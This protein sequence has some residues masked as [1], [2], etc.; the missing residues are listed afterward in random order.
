MTSK[1]GLVVGGD[2][3]RIH[4]ILT[5]FFTS[6]AWSSERSLLLIIIIIII[7]IINELVARALSAAAIPNTKEPQGLCR[8]DRKRP[9]GLTLVP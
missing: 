7:I 9:D 8:S 4:T 6:A 3:M 1:K 5:D 2:P